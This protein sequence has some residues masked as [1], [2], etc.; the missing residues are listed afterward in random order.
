VS[1]TQEEEAFEPMDIDA[2]HQEKPQDTKTTRKV[3]VLTFW[4]TRKR[5]PAFKEAFGEQTFTVQTL[6]KEE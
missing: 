6:P 4:M 2:P 5:I 1:E 3:P